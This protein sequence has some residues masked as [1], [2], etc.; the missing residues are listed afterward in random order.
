MRIVFSARPSCAR[1][2]MN[3]QPP[4]FPGSELA[5]S[6][7]FHQPFRVSRADLPGSLSSR[8]AAHAAR[9]AVRPRNQQR[10]PFVSS[11]SLHLGKLLV[12]PPLLSLA[13][14]SQSLP[15]LSLPLP[16]LP[17]LRSPS[18]PL[19]AAVLLPSIERI[20][21]QQ[22]VLVARLMSATGPCQPH[23]VLCKQRSCNCSRI[24]AA[25]A[26]PSP[27]CPDWSWLSGG[28]SHTAPRCLSLSAPPRP[29]SSISFC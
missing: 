28:L 19:H 11:Q 4:A 26:E 24:D 16:P 5:Q 29:T 1:S 6:W 22:A 27:P 3:I 13:L 10:G 12:Y 18:P 25:P 20:S 23:R 21:L 15:L 17:L 14:F 7:I 2:V 9:G 8:S